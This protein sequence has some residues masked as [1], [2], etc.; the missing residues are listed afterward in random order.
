[1]IQ[2]RT[3]YLNQ[4]LEWDFIEKKKDFFLRLIPILLLLAIT[5]PFIRSSYWDDEIFSVVSARSWSGMFRIFREYENNMSLYLLILHGWMKLF[6]D[7]ETATHALSLLFAA[8]SLPV[9]YKLERFWFNKTSSLA[10]TLL[11]ASNPLFVFYA[12]ESRSYSML[13]FSCVLSTLVFVRLLRRPG[14]GLATLYGVCIA[15]GVYIHYFGILLLIVHALALTRSNLKLDSMRWFALSAVVFLI[16]ILPLALFPPLNKSQIDWI[17]K[18][19]ARFLAYTIKDLFGGS[20]V[21]GLLILCFAFTLWKGYRLKGQD[22][23]LFRFALVWAVLPASLLFVFSWLVKPAY[24]TRFFVWCIPGAVFLTSLI[25]AWVP[26][27]RWGKTLVWMLVLIFFIKGAGSGLQSKGSGYREAVKYLHANFHRGEIILTYPYFKSIHAGY[28]LE[29]YAGT[30]SSV[31]PLVITRQPFLPG[32]G[33]I[34]P[35]PDMDSLKKMAA[36][37]SRVYLICKG[38]EVPTVTDTVQNRLWLPK[39]QQTIGNR[40]PQ[41]RTKLFGEGSQDP[42]RVIVY[43]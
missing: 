32:G 23:Y 8:L 12:V 43:E 28:Y 39:I 7:G 9:F 18:P 14:F 34:D 19:P 27:S 42:V 29:K 24:Q 20:L 17:T 15:A 38:S 36:A 10:A 1:M 30:D 4:P 21:A 2:S 26:W 3:P 33:G 37:Y 22:L 11:F 40:H 13:V 41:A 6:G 35:D 31:R 5:I 16:C 25:F